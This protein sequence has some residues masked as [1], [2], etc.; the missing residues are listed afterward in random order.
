[1]ERGGSCIYVRDRVQTKEQNC[2]QELCKDKDFEMSI[3]ELVDY[4]NS[5]C[6][7]L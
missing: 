3:V 1:M 2:V 4:K 5:S 7:Y 6:V